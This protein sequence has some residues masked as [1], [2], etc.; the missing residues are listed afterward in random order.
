LQDGD[1]TRDV[2]YTANATEPT[3][4]SWCYENNLC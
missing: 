1:N 4:S 3:I 2:F